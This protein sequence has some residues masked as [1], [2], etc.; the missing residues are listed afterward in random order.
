MLGRSAFRM[1]QISNG[2]GSASP[3]LASRLLHML[4]SQSR[5]FARYRGIPDVGQSH[6]PVPWL[7]CKTLSCLRIISRQLIGIREHTS[8]LGWS[9]SDFT[10]FT[11]DSFAFLFINPV[12]RI[13]GPSDKRRRESQKESHEDKRELHIAQSSNLIQSCV[14]K[15]FNKLHFILS[16]KCLIILNKYYC[17][18]KASPPVGTEQSEAALLTWAPI[19]CQRFYSR[20]QGS[21][22]GPVWEVLFTE[23]K[24]L[25]PYFKPK[26]SA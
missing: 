12:T 14:K 19:N 15:G 17:V 6:T 26:K 9:T 25:K 13:R 18:G 1:F 10:N 8:I 24:T 2:G 21:L 23:S 22:G 3:R 4:H 11:W 5:M 7:S 16:V 20:R